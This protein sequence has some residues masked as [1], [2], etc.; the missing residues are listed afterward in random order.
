MTSHTHIRRLIL[1]MILGTAISSS[2]FAQPNRRFQDSSMTIVTK[3]PFEGRNYFITIVPIDTTNF[4]NMP[5]VGGTPRPT[6]T[7]IWRD[8]IQRLLP[9]SVVRK[10]RKWELFPQEKR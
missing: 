7:I 5:I 1:A 4:D 9:D 10:L 6:T 3:V 8:S 2:L